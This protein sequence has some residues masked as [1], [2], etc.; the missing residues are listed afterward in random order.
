MLETL[1]IGADDCLFDGDCEPI[2]WRVAIGA[3]KTCRAHWI[4]EYLS[5]L[6]ID[7]VIPSKN[8]EGRDGRPVELDREGYRDRNIVQRLFGWFKEYR[9]IISRFEKTAK[10]FCG[11]IKMAFIQG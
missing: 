7:R 1:L 9:R 4:D 10:N 8:N 3:E 11:M 2:V 5:G 6:G